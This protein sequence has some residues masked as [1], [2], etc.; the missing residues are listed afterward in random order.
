MEESNGTR[1]SRPVFFFDIDNCV[2]SFYD[3]N[4]VLI[5][6]SLLNTRLALSYDDLL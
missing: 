1:D 3:I 2:R 5:C 4:Q 6:G